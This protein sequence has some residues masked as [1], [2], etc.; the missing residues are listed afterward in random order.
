MK[1]DAMIRRFRRL[2]ES[3]DN[4]FT[5]VVLAPDDEAS[6]SEFCN[7]CGPGDLTQKWRATTDGVDGWAVR[8]RCWSA[9]LLYQ[10]SPAVRLY[11]A[12]AQGI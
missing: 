8:Q 6:Y 11:A 9:F 2:L 1:P 7:V 4:T 3:G 12:M 10:K 5:V